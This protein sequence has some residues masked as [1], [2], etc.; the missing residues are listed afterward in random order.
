MKIRPVWIR[1]VPCGRTDV[2]K[3]VLTFRNFVKAPKNW[4]YKFQNRLWKHVK[5]IVNI[6]LEFHA[7]SCETYSSIINI[8]TLRCNE[9]F[10][11]SLRHS[12]QLFFKHVPSAVPC[13]IRKIYW[14]S[15]RSQLNQSS[16]TLRVPNITVR[17]QMNG[18]VSK[19]NKKFI[20]HL[21][22]AKRTPL[23][24]ATVPVSYVLTFWWRIFF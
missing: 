15:H 13:V 8:N 16:A 18:A 14:A 21:T 2:T 6:I 24:A 4:K 19:V 1:V 7:T 20:S 12:N 17:L 9:Y 5:N 22:R 11:E 3:L 23:A 10:N